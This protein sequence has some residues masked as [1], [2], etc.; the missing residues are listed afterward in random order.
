MKSTALPSITG[1][2]ASGPMAPSPSTAV[3]FESTATRFWRDV[4]LAAWP[5]SAAIELA[6]RGDA[7]RIGEREVA[8]IAERLRGM[9]LELA[10]PRKAMIGERARAQILGHRR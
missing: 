6:R 8:L 1:F 3:P 4:R 10:R 9:D 2:E 7:G 5:G